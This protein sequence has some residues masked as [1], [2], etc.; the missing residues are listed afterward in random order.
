MTPRLAFARATTDL[1]RSIDS[2]MLAFVF[3]RENV[4]LAA[5][6]TDTLSST[7]RPA[8]SFTSTA[9]SMPFSFGM[10]TE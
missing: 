2:S 8:R 4:W 3:F 1:N 10:S 7:R 5:V 6:N 9:C